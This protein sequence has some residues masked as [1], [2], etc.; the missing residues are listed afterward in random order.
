MGACVRHERPRRKPH[1]GRP[2]RMSGAPCLRASECRRYAALT[3]HVA[4]R[5]ASGLARRTK[6]PAVLVVPRSEATS[7]SLVAGTLKRSRARRC[8][9]AAQ[10]ALDPGAPRGERERPTASTRPGPLQRASQPPNDVARLRTPGVGLGPVLRTHTAW[11]IRGPS[12]GSLESTDI[13]RGPPQPAPEPAGGGTVR[14]AAKLL[15]P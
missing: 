13:D 3:C 14:L 11:R 15:L 10:H 4:T 7:T 12:V 5:R 6:R 9:A 8:D 2:W 1:R